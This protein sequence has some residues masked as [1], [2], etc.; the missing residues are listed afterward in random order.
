MNSY[1]A[2]NTD[3]QETGQYRY[4]VEKKSSVLANALQ[5]QQLIHIIKKHT[6]NTKTLLDVGCGD[7][8]YTVALMRGI[9]AKK[10]MGFDPAEKPIRFAKRHIPKDLKGKMTFI[11]ADILNTS[12]FITPGSFDVVVVRGVLHHLE[13]PVP[14]I[15]E[16]SKVAEHLYILEPNGYNPVLKIIE[17]TSKYHRD[18]REKSYFPPTLNRWII[19]HGFTIREQKFFS[20]LPFFAPDRVT[21]ILVALSPFFESLRGIKLLYCA[22]NL[23]YATKKIPSVRNK[24]Q[25]M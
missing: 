14:A 9:G 21:D 8:T 25:K 18:H 15:A 7:G 17:K 6:P 20:I 13:N 11:V 3:V 10:A 1:K 24:R 4:T 5:T 12:S 16:L 23:I 22:S 19:E 2:F